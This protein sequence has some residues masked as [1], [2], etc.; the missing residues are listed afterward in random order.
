MMTWRRIASVSFAAFAVFVGSETARGADSSEDLGL[1]GHYAIAH[2]I[3]WTGD[4]VV[5][6]LAVQL[7]NETDRPVISAAVAVERPD[8]PEDQVENAPEWAFAILPAIDILPGTSA[9]AAARVVLPAGEWS[10]WQQPGQAPSFRVTFHD[11]VAGIVSGTLRL[12]QTGEIPEQ[13]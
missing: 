10:R 11:D 8:A 5:I 6:D 12:S 9:R 3:V 7:T 4:Q 1:V 13:R 2:D